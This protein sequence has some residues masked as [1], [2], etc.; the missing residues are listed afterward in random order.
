MG[1]LESLAEETVKRSQKTTRSAG[2]ILVILEYGSRESSKCHGK[3]YLK[4]D[5]SRMTNT[6]FYRILGTNSK[7]YTIQT[8]LLPPRSSHELQHQM[9]FWA[10]T[11]NTTTRWHHS[12]QWGAWDCYISVG[13]HRAKNGKALGFNEI[14]VEVLNNETG[15]KYLHHLFSKC[16]ETGLAPQL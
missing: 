7:V 6:K 14:P 11:R 4:M 13:C 5:Q 16:L 1:T 15:I 9:S 2:N 3:L 10:T 12:D 8:H